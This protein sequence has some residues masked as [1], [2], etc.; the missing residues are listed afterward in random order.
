MAFQEV[1]CDFSSGSNLNGGYP[2]TGG[3]Y[4]ITYTNGGWNSGTGVFTPAAGDPAAEGVTVGDLASVYNDGASVG[5]FIGRVTARTSTTITVSTTA[6][7]GTA[8]STNATAR[9][10]KVGGTLKGP[11]AA[12]GFPL[13]LIAGTLTDASGNTP[14]VNLKNTAN[15]DITANIAAS[16]AG[17]WRLE[18]MTSSPGDGGRAIIDGGTSG[19]SY[20]LLT[21]SNINIDL[22]GITGQNNGATGSAS[23]FSISQGNFLHRC[24]ASNSRGNGFTFTGDPSTVVE[25]E[26]FACNASNT[27]NKAG[28]ESTVDR[29][30]YVRCI[31]HDNTGS[32]TRGFY[33]T[34]GAE[35][36]DCIADTNGSDGFY[37]SAGFDFTRFIGCDSYNNGG[38]GIELAN[39]STA[40][41]YLENCNLIDNG[42]WGINGSGAGARNGAVINCGFG[43]GT[44]A[45]T[46]GTTTGLKSMVESGSVTYG[47]NVV[48]YVDAPNGDFRVNVSAAHAGRGTFTQTAASYAGTVGYPNIGAAQVGDYP[49]QADVESGVTYAHGAY[50]GSLSAG[51][52]AV[53]GSN[54]TGGLQ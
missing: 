53:G 36:I 1:Y 50:T 2:A 39:V 49:A 47:S 43:A 30:T 16:G 37:T 6:K 20:I 42:G 19:A 45:N 14:R 13:N 41:L 10:I 34:Q 18:G 48:P 29:I 8:P 54:M 40:Y 15:Y 5:V 4:P 51:G 27:A 21:T 22:V 46:S 23:I 25:C 9:T 44:A 12:S 17:P 3:A 11:N 38:D 7:I 28:F 26:A 52:G 35:F 31:A 33:T 24:V 32:N